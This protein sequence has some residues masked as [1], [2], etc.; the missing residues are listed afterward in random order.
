MFWFA[1][2]LGYA[3][4]NTIIIITNQRSIYI[5]YDK[6]METKMECGSKNLIMINN[7][8]VFGTALGCSS[9]VKL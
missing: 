1:W 5:V 9:S 6:R 2:E 3:L 8:G 4:G 7:K